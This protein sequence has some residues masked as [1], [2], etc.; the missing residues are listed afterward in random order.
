MI[1]TNCYLC[2]L[3]N[4]NKFGLSCAKL[5][6]RLDLASK[7]EG[8]I[9]VF[10]PTGGFKYCI[11]LSSLCCSGSPFMGRL[12]TTLVTNILVIIYPP[13]FFSLPGPDNL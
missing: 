2:Q 7:E 8:G 9:I 11:G 5:R 4:I 10:R 6:G 13:C 12:A 1:S 3:C